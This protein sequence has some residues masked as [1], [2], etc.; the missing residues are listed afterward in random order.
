MLFIEK[1]K[2]ENFIH[3]GFEVGLFFKGID[4]LLEI[5]GGILLIYLNPGRMSHLVILLT[6]GE[7]S[8]D[9]NDL[10]ANALLHLSRSFSIN[11]QYF[12]E[13]YL[14]SHG[15]IKCFLVFLL[16][17]KKLWAYPLTIVSLLMFIAYQIYK[18]STQP[19]VSLLLL[20]VF[21]AIMIA[22]TFIEYRR[23]KADGGDN[24][25]KMPKGIG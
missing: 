5:L 7:L 3:I 22:L 10:T 9:P 24:K 23:M 12:G 13:F 14:L 6:R 19:S 8:E 1:L 21:D 15:I 17:R 20:T 11:T 25:R 4:G 16:L 18:Y 2:K